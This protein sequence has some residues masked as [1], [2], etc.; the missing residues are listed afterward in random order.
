MSRRGCMLIA[1]ALLAVSC[2]SPARLARKSGEELAQGDLDH[3]YDLAR[4]AIEKD[5]ANAEARAAYE[6]ASERLGAGWRE[7]VHAQAAGDSGAAADL[8]MSYGRF[9]SEVLA[10]GLSLHEEPGWSADEALLYRTAAQRH[11]QRGRDALAAKKPKAAFAAFRDCRR[12]IPGYADAA[13]MQARALRLATVRVAVLPFAENIDVP[14]LTLEMHRRT[15][16]E[17]ARQAGGEFTFTALVPTDSVDDALTLA[18]AQEPTRERAIAAGRRLG[19]QRVVTGRFAGLRSSNDS[20]ESVQPFVHRVDVRDDKG[21]THPRW[22]TGELTVITRSREVKLQTEIEVID[23]RTGATVARRT[24]PGEAFARTVWTDFR[25]EGDCTRYALLD[26]ETRKAEPD[27]A[28]AADARWKEGAGS[29]TLPA[30]LER[31]QKD[32]DRARYKSDYRREFLGDTRSRPVWL[33]ELPSED[34]LA[35]C[36]L[37]ELWKPVLAALQ[38]LDAKE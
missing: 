27:R 25:P 26:P 19:A 35:Y 14:G 13:S 5:A 16:A 31:A 36:A 20:K 17:V 9:R 6:R 10:H 15:A 3:A 8:V 33:G 21:V 18:D 7:R 4:R 38:E 1:V 12:F 37:E 28:K 29:W 32:R 11:Y 23:V 24:V 22:D 2:A 34:D 30:L